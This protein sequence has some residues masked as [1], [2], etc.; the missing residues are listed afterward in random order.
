MKIKNAPQN[1]FWKFC[2]TEIELKLIKKIKIK[3]STK[4]F[5]S[6]VQQQLI[7]SIGQADLSYYPFLE[8]LE[9]QTVNNQL[10]VKFPDKRKYKI[11]LVEIDDDS[12]YSEENWES[13]LHDLDN[14]LA[15][16][17]ESQKEERVCE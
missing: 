14:F 8:A 5:E 2:A 10:L 4:S 9:F 11:Q 6:F 15:T 1:I 3:M 12:R 17:P 7:Y 16:L 13:F